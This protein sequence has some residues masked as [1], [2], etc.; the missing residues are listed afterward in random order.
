MN[1]DK[2][3]ILDTLARD[4]FAKGGFNGAWLYAEN[5][6]IVSKGAVGFSDLEDKVPLREDSLFDLASVSKQFT[7]AAVM[8]LRRRGLL[9]LEDEITKFFPEIPYRGV[10]V[11]H[12]LNHTGGLPDYM[13]WVDETAKKENTIPNNAVIVRFLCECGEAPS[14]APGEQF[15]YSN[16]GY[17]L[18]AQIVETVAGVPFEKFLRDNVFEP[19]GMHATRVYHRRM[20][21][22][23]IPNLAWGL[24]LPLGADRYELPDDLPEE[25]AAVT[26]D[27]ANGDGLVHSN[28]L[29]LFQWDRALRAGT[30]LTKEE[31]ALMA[32]PGRLNN[33]EI[34]IDKDG[35]DDPDY[36]YGFGWDVLNDPDFGLIVCHSGGWPGYSTWYERFVDADRVLIRLRCRDVRDERASQSFAGGLTAIARDR[37]PEPVRSIEELAVRNPDQSGWGSLVG[38]YD[39]QIGDF[40]IEEIF[41]KDGTL[42]ARANNDGRTLALRLWPLGENRSG[43]KDLDAD[44]SFSENGLTLYGVTG[45]KTE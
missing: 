15:E 17:C 41:R 23:E 20:D 25:S 29:D 12:L 40:R 36:G 7:A 1:V 37:A 21:K 33:G 44:L 34:C 22:I 24:S 28:V 5:G 31:Q 13:D 32:T 8:L 35:D 2:K 14:F 10:T 26:C 11:R 4:A 42:Y 30:V 38:K 16:T 6:E 39:Y 3:I 19:A 9:S 27:G 43:I 45:R 18:L